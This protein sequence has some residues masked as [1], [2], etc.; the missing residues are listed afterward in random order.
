MKTNIYIITLSFAAISLLVGGWGELPKEDLGGPTGSALSSVAQLAAED[1]STGTGIPLSYQAPV[2]KPPK[3]I[4]KPGG[5]V[6]GGTRGDESIALFAL[7]PD[8]LGLTINPQPTLYWYLSKPAPYPLI[9]T[10][11]EDTRTKPILETI[12]GGSPK[13]GIYSVP[14][15]A[16][17]ITLEMD[18]EYQ[19]FVSLTVDP[20]SQS[21]DLVAGGMIKRIVPGEELRKKLK[22]ARPEQLTT[23]YSEEGLWY[24]ALSSISNL[25]ETSPKDNHYCAGRKDLLEQIDLSLG[26]LEIAKAEEVI[27]L[28]QG[29]FFPFHFP[30]E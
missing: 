29:P 22:D 7:V 4:G 2:Y 25:C 12:F 18:I 14:L 13:A 16:F 28:P 15:K 23:I 10:L 3:G 19:W 1:R 26:L 8:H 20:N 27:L 21:K 17:D 11:N 30:P 9:F 24:D 5:R 6:G